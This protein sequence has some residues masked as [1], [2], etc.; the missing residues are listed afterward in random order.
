M[1]LPFFNWVG[2]F[3]Y[4][5]NQTYSGSTYNSTYAGYNNFINWLNY[6]GNYSY[7]GDVQVGIKNTTDWAY[8]A[9]WS[10]ENS[11]NDEKGIYN[12]TSY[13]NSWTAS[14]KID[15]GASF[16]GDDYLRI[17]TAVVQQCSNVTMATWVKLPST[18]TS[19]AFINM[20][21]SST[22]YAIGV[23]GSTYDNSGND[24]I[25]LVNGF[26]WKDSGKL[27]GTSWAHVA[28]TV[29]GSSPRQIKT[30]IN[31]ANVYNVT[32]INCGI[33]RNRTEIGADS[34]EGGALIRAVDSGTLIDEARIYG[35]VLT[36]AEI[37]NLYQLGNYH[38]HT[39][40]QNG[41]I[42]VDASLTYNETIL[43]AKDFIVQ[44]EISDRDVIRDLTRLTS[45]KD[46]K[47][48]DYSKTPEL[49]DKISFSWILK[50]LIQLTQGV[51]E[52]KT[53]I[54]TLTEKNTELEK[55]NILIKSELC[56]KDNSYIWCKK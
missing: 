47:D 23:G 16:D 21:N 30:Y 28:F 56:K 14:G 20:G 5:Y 8:G 25:I 17:D 34:N 6:V 33:P 13:G 11:G 31:G 49:K 51:T 10:L 41:T 36:P 26:S 3:A 18:S 40:T 22:G 48:I 2:G 50:G 45:K 7:I 53:R 37:A 12:M 15:S 29:D 52:L 4:N 19:G 42:S 44:S 46:S 32:E 43:Y 38:N 27:I 54:G 55:E 1:S 35:R 39:I 24:L 9:L